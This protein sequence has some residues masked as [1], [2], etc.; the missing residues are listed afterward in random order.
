LR[1]R[2]T[3][4][5]KDYLVNWILEEAITK[6]EILLGSGIEKEAVQALEDAVRENPR[7][8]QPRALLA[9]LFVKRADLERAA[10]EFEIALRLDPNDAAS[11]YQLALLYQ[12]SGA[13][14]RAEEL[15]AKVGKAR[16]EDPSRSAPRNLVRIIR[17]GSQ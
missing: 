15:F 7:A 5:P 1:A 10:R 4:D 8:A 14:G 3:L 2:L 9:R 13:T 11:A 12:K 17:E 16:A 6:E